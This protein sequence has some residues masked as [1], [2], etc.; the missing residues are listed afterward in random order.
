MALLSR[1][2]SKYLKQ[3]ETQKEN[4]RNS[5][6]DSSLKNIQ[7]F[8]CKGFG[9]VRSECANLLKKKALTSIKSGSDSDSDDE[10]AL[11]NFMAL[12][13]FVS[14]S[15]S[16]PATETAAETPAKSTYEIL[17]RDMILD[18]MENPQKQKLFFSS[19]GRRETAATSASEPK[20]IIASKPKPRIASEPKPRVTIGTATATKTATASRK[21][22]EFQSASQRFFR[23]ICHPCGVARHIR[24]RCFK[25]LRENHRREQAYDERFRGPTC[26]RCGVEGH[27]QRHCF[28]FSRRFVHEGQRFKKVWVRKDDLYGN[29][30]GDWSCFCFGVIDDDAIEVKSVGFTYIV[31][32][33]KIE[34]SYLEFFLYHSTVLLR[35]LQEVIQKLRCVI[36]G[37][38]LVY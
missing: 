23:P 26:Y 14:S 11:K 28:G 18:L 10:L 16:E 6:V 7:C 38:E 3:K 17:W 20:P 27:I 34:M 37:E 19:E 21:F 25:L 24:P 29:V 30:W 22:L 12:T 5:E 35:L 4:G 2:F 33:G 32:K 9:H 8:E 13:T 15:V 36:C 1:Q 31:K